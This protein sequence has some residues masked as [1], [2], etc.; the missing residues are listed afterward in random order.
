MLFALTNRRADEP[1]RR[2]ALGDRRSAPELLRHKVSAPELLRH[3]VAAPELLRHKVAAAELA[4]QEG[5]AGVLR[6]VTDPARG[7]S[8]RVVTGERS[9]ARHWRYEW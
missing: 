3:K 4:R 9:L 2:C 1:A 6:L 7:L 8:S 5:R